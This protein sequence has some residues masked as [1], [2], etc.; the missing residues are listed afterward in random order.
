MPTDNRISTLPEI[1]ILY[2]DIDILD[3][4]PSSTGQSDADVLFLI[5]KSG[6][7]NEKI[8]FKN[9]KSSILGNTVALTG[10]QIIS[11]EKTFTD[12]CTFEDTV[13]LNEVV[14]T[15]QSGDI[16]GYD[17]VG[18]TGYFEKMGVG[19]NFANKSRQP[20]CDLHVEG[21]VCV[22]GK[23]NALGEISFSGALGV[24]DIDASGNLFVNG[25]GFFHS[26]LDVYA[27]CEVSGD[28]NVQGYSNFA[29]DINVSGD[30]N[31]GHKII[32]HQDDDTFISFED[33]QITFQAGSGNKLSVSQDETAF[34]VSGEQKVGLNSSGQFS[35]NTDSPIGDLSVSGDAYIEKVYIT[36]SNGDW[37]QIIPQK[38]DE[39]VNFTTN[40]IGGQEIYEI[41]FPK[42]FGAP[43]IVHASLR[44]DQG[45][46][47]RFFNISNISTQSYH[48][49]FNDTIPDNNYYV[50]TSARTTDDYSI[51][52]TLTQSFRTQII[53]G[54]T[55]YTIN[56]PSA[57]TKTPI[58]SVTLER[59]SSYTP[60][61]IG[62]A[63]DTFI[64]GWEYYVATDTN[65]WR[66]VTMAEIIRTEGA[67][68][69]TDFDNDFYYV[70]I[71]G[72]LWGKIPLVTSTKSD[73]GN[74]GDVQY[75]NN[76]IY[77]LT[78]EGWKEG[79]IATWPAESS[80]EILPHMISNVTENSFQ[81]NFAGT[82]ASQYFVHTVASR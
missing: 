54:N 26:G 32:H 65:T 69:D 75:D 68:G 16:S 4:I 47:I 25:S 49:S 20:T 11:G 33:N 72:T 21:D 67:A 82:L 78:A 22:E 58:V 31:V 18:T 70:C 1:S 61:D 71:D 60:T 27:D 3:P 43:P 28:L 30:L 7:K 80:V 57:F 9:L 13:F 14:D 59:K 17:F 77:V 8:T 38:Y 29:Q 44:N 42:T 66:R 39:S 64:D 74:L 63:G 52:D 35:I 56:F 48:I 81:I 50:E 15:T 10:N 23:L 12:I 45:G 55:D 36:G 51:H 46:D 73:A 76:Y 37:Q 62:T 79:A 24:N 53:E 2:S 6:V 19:P 41:D 40:L 34:Y 5:T